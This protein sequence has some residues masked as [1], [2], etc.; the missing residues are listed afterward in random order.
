MNT[1]RSTTTL[2]M[3]QSLD[4][5]ITS[6]DND[7]MDFD[8]DLPN[9]PGVSEGLYQYYDLEKKTDWYSLN[10]GRVMAKIGV[11]NRREEPKKA[12]VNFVI[13]DSKPHLSKQ[14]V[15]YLS[16]WVKKLYLVTTNE[17]HPGY[18]M[19]NRL[20]NIEMI[21]YKN[22]INLKNL[23]ETLKSDY[24]INNITIQS[25]GT[26]NS[27][28]IREGLIDRISVIIAPCLVGGQNTQS[29]IGGE[30]FHSTSE[31][32]KIK[33]LKLIKCDVLKDSY[34]HVVY[35]VLNKK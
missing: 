28:W 13:I 12:N 2:F 18:E 31:L 11:N 26:L 16:G 4:G 34:L 7:R 23:L 24:K 32:S 5:K 20:G 14:G 30:S 9:I 3:L 22:T 6:G 27:H 21:Y 19:Q 33:A 25:G 35:E 17:K 1:K 15:E 8:K 10:T 29:L